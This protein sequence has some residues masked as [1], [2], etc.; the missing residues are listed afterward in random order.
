MSDTPQRMKLPLTISLGLV[1]ALA[2]L[3]SPRHSAPDQG[4]SATSQR[5]PVLVELFTS[6]GC[7]S[8][9]P[10]DALMAKLDMQQPVPGADVIVLEQ[11]VDYW[12]DQG[13]KDP[14]A[15]QAATQRQKESAFALGAEVYTPQMVIDGCT[16]ILG[17]DESRARNVIQAA[18]KS[19]KAKIQIA[20]AGAASGDSRTLQIHAGNLPGL[21]PV[22]PSSAGKK[23]KTSNA[24]V[25]LAIT[26]SRLHS[27]VRRG[28]NAG[29]GLEHDGV[30]RQFMKLGPATPGADTSFDSSTTVMLSKEWRRENLRAVVFVQNPRTRQIYGS[31]SIP[32]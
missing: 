32:F 9:P 31:A 16:V 1:V 29:R 24:E 5:S 26:E 15:S 18:E 30:V 19:T 13:W 10:A 23:P 21:A 20:W 12:D 7:S 2:S 25:F 28:E 11:H 3:A 8:C 27:D 4:A 14:F 22:P 6:E 17:S